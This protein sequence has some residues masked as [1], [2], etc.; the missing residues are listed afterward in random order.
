MEYD[1]SNLGWREDGVVGYNF[2]KMVVLSLESIQDLHYFSRE[3]N[4][5]L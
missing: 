1:L 3:I 2:M 4:Y 5:D